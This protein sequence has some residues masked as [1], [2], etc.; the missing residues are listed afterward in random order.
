MEAPER[1]LKENN[2]QLS[3]K[4]ERETDND[5]RVRTRILEHQNNQ[6]KP[7]RDRSSWEPPPWHIRKEW[8]KAKAKWQ[9]E[10]LLPF[11]AFDP[12]K[13]LNPGFS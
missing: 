2:V 10:A 4:L 13:V 11:I 5:L 12:L 6:C 8:M 3:K 9:R 7:G 1:N